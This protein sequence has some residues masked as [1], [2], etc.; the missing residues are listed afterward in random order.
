M[1]N[2]HEFARPKI[3][4]L[5]HQNMT[6]SHISHFYLAEDTAELN[7][8]VENVALSYRFPNPNYHVV[9]INRKLHTMG[10]VKK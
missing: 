8:C 2:V 5:A 9:K 7:K 4:C 10:F 6:L 3:T 1:Y